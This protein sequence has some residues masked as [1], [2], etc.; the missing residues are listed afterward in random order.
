MKEAAN[1]LSILFHPIFAPMYVLFIFFNDSFQDR[2]FMLVPE[3]LANLMY[4]TTLML[5][6]V[7]PLLS[8]F[9][10]QR[11]KIIPHMRVVEREHRGKV[12]GLLLMYY[13]LMTGLMMYKGAQG[14]P[15]PRVVIA[16]MILATL[17]ILFLMLLNATVHKISGHSYAVWFIVGFTFYIASIYKQIGIPFLVFTMV[18]A[19]LVNYS[20]L[21][22]KAHTEGEVITGSILGITLSYFGLLGLELL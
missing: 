20:R 1:V 4:V 13:G 2:T 19:L 18:L 10:L 14:V 6:I 15:F 7:F 3:G 21:Y 22:L 12:Y 9:I 16:V 11:Y 8:L 17:G 5:L